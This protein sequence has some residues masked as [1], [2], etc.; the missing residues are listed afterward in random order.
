MGHTDPKRALRDYAKAM[1][2]DASEVERLRALAGEIVDESIVTNGHSRVR[3]ARVANGSALAFG[4]TMR[5][6]GA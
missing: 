6:P 1:R 5:A 2:R 3:A 4:S